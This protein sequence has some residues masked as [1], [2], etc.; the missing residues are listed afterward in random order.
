[1]TENN[2]APKPEVTGRSWNEKISLAILCALMLAAV[3]NVG[4]GRN[5]EI[6]EGVAVMDYPAYKFYSGQRD[7]HF[8]GAGYWLVP[9]KEFHDVVPAPGGSAF[10]FAH[11]DDALHAIRSEER[12]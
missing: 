6:F 12:R 7:C 4:R 8:S 2:H 3:V 5:N 10:D 1:M 9:N 11:Y